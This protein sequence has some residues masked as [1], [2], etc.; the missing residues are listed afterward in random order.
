M[1]KIAVF[2]IFSIAF[3]VFG[4]YA[5]SPEMLN[6]QAVLRNNSGDLIVDKSVDV[7]ISIID[8][9]ADGDVLFTESHTKT[10]NA[11]GIVNLV[12]G[13]GTPI[14]NEFS[15]IDWA[16]DKRFVGVKVDVGSGLTDLGAFQLLSVPYAL[17]ANSASNL[18]SENIYIPQSDTLFAVKDH[19]GNVVFAVFPDGVKIIV[20]EVAKGS[21]GGFAVSGRTPT[22]G[23]TD[24]FRVT[25]DSTRI[26]VNDT[27]QSK[28]S[29]G[30]FAVSGRT[31]TKGINDQYMVVTFDSTRIFVND[32]VAGFGIANNESGESENLLNINKQNYLIGHNAGDSLTTGKYNSMIGYE[33]GYSSKTANNN[34]FFGHRSGY[35]NKSGYENVFIGNRTGYGFIGGYDNIFIGNLAGENSTW[36]THNTFIGNEAGKNIVGDDNICIGDRTGYNSY[37]T[38]HEVISTTIV[39]VDAARNLSGY[40]NTIIGTAAGFSAGG[41]S[42]G[43]NNVFVGTY[44]GGGNYLNRLGSNNVCLGYNAGAS[45]TGDDQLYIA[46]NS[47][48]T[49]IYG[50]FASGSEMV[51]INGDFH[52]TGDIS[53]D[54]HHPIADYVFESNYKLET[55]EEH[56][57]FMWNNKHLPAVTSAKEIEIEGKINMNERRE[58]LLEELEKAHIYIEQLNNEVKSIKKENEALKQKLNE[59]IEM[60]ENK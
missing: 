60:L 34:L 27:V 56:A 43:S 8:N 49:L 50:N 10:T 20:E 29:V 55:I 28:G 58:Q 3:T 13:T 59:I 21:V 31:P 36:A 5:Q 40:E 6:Y 12:I 57:E 47:T 46:N 18:G 2:L 11:Y 44:A 14:L 32:S 39:G 35:S 25:P 33:A 52:V 41:S 24:I 4:G 26:Y 23:E 54:G 1:K 30:G 42:T 7:E 51:Q 45:K 53:Y 9:N 15:D 38:E 17:H 19:E 22:K 37:E 16:A 48:T